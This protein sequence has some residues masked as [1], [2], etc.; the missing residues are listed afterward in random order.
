MAQLEASMQVVNAGQKS[1]LM[2]RLV[3]VILLLDGLDGLVGVSE[4]TVTP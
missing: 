2:A 4:V 1:I 3:F